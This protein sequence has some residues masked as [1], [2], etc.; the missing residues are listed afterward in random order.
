MI[1]GF[2]TRYSM[3]MPIALSIFII[4][5]TLGAITYY[6]LIYPFIVNKKYRQ[7]NPMPV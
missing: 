4:L 1:E 6:Y 3:D 5:F 7:S 2:L